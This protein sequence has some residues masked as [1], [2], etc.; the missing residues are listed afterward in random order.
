MGGTKIKVTLLLIDCV[1]AILNTVVLNSSLMTMSAPQC[2]FRLL[3]D[4]IDDCIGGGTYK[5]SIIRVHNKIW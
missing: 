5:L 1:Q 2:H 3:A 4:R